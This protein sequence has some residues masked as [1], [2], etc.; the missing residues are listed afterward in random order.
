MGLSVFFLKN[1]KIKAVAEKSKAHFCFPSADLC[2]LGQEER[3]LLEVW[4]P[5]GPCKSS[6]PSKGQQERPGQRLPSVLRPALVV[7]DRVFLRRWAASRGAQLYQARLLLPGNMKN[8]LD[9]PR[10]MYSFLL[11]RNNYSF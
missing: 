9:M 7:W 5:L 4:V 10:E 6:S 3:M 2:S 1:K 8:P 11:T